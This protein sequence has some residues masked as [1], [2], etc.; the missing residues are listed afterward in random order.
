MK[1]TYMRIYTCR[2]CQRFCIKP[3]NSKSYENAASLIADGDVFNCDMGKF[4]DRYFTYVEGFGAFTEV[5]YQTPQ[6]WK[7]ALER[8]LILLKL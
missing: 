2:D 7:N 1:K 6:E 3:E 4:N 8:L 5:S